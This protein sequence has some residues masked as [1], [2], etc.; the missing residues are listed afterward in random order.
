MK[1]MMYRFD[2]RMNLVVVLFLF[3]SL[4]WTLNGGDK[5]FNG[6]YVPIEG[7][8]KTSAYIYELE[9]DTQIARI[10]PMQTVGLYGVNRDNSMQN[11]F[12]RIHLPGW[13]ALFFLYMTSMMEVL[14][15]LMFFSLFLWSMLP[16]AQQERYEMF[17]DRTV[18]RVSFKMSILIFLM[19]SSGDILFGERQELWEHGTFIVLCLVTYDMWYRADQFFIEM[20]DKDISEDNNGDFSSTQA[21]SYKKKS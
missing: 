13:L 10:Q 11:M 1:N 8:F 3:W 2:R 20:R 9:S 5:L 14:L 18:H 4:F 12:A 16:A 19:F 15:G 6:D 17:A 21:S 7:S